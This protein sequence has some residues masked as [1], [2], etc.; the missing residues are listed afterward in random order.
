VRR[1][2][3]GVFDVRDFGAVGDG[4]TDDSSALNAA[5]WYASRFQTVGQ[6]AAAGARVV[7]PPGD[8]FC[9]SPVHLIGP[10]CLEGPSGGA[11]APAILRFDQDVGAPSDPTADD[12][13][14]GCVVLH[15]AGTSPIP[16]RVRAQAYDV[17]DL[18]VPVDGVWAGLY[19]R[20]IATTGDRKTSG[21]T[22]DPGF[23]TNPLANF[24]VPITDGNVTLA[25]W[26]ALDGASGAIVRRLVLTQVPGGDLSKT[27]S[28]V[29]MHAAGRLEDLHIQGFQGDGIH[30]R[31]AAVAGHPKLSTNANLWSMSGKVSVHDC[32]RYGMK[33][34]GPDSNAGH[35]E[36][37][38]DLTGNQSYGLWSKAPLGNLYGQI[39]T[40]GN[41]L[42]IDGGV[43]KHNEVVVTPDPA[44]PGTDTPVVLGQLCLPAPANR[45]G[46]QYRCTKA[47]RTDLVAEPNWAAHTDLD[48]PYF[49]DGTAHWT[50]FMEEGG[51]IRTVTGTGAI[52]VFERVYAEMNQQPA[53]IGTDVLLG[54]NAELVM[55]K[56]S[57]PLLGMAKGF[58]LP[59]SVVSRTQEA[60]PALVMQIDIGNLSDQNL[61]LRFRLAP[62]PE[63]FTPGGAVPDAHD[64]VF[65][66]TVGDP[67]GDYGQ[68]WVMQ[69]GTGAGSGVSYTQC[70]SIQLPESGAMCFP[71]LFLG[72]QIRHERRVTT[73]FVA[74][75]T[76]RGSRPD[77]TNMVSA[78]GAYRPGDVL[79]NNYVDNDGWADDPSAKW[80]VLW[81]PDTF[82]GVTTSGRS[83]DYP[84]RVGDV[85]YVGDYAYRAET[86]GLSGHDPAV[87]SWFAA[88]TGRGDLLHDATPVDKMDGDIEWRNVG[89]KTADLP[90]VPLLVERPTMA[91]VTTAGLA[92]KTLDADESAYARFKL[93]GADQDVTVNL[94]PGPANGWVRAF[95]NANTVAGGN[96]TVT[97]GIAGGGLTVPIAAE[98]LAMI[99]SDG[100]DCFQL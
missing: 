31:G 19:Y 40:H 42:V 51:S 61:G 33:I 15:A 82:G 7:V 48:E 26:G 56:D 28:G 100:N 35:V 22:D 27:C 95:W 62:S 20:V 49:V 16:T 32:G 86:A 88:T 1:A 59:H 79:L 41:G 29:R 68:R 66:R 17:G 80:P 10:S 69:A 44:W 93:V 38:L 8:Y 63:G 58:F 9:T 54:S 30:I 57:T 98:S 45:T 64:L 12:T 89:V 85:V 84:Y 65:K 23:L 34:Y 4:A 11:D 3:D 50:C 70:Q 76:P 5:L 13:D 78:F 75:D 77:T 87:A 47:G 96:Y 60:S 94:Q 67:F 72:S 21:A 92:T 73:A 2:H 81:R 97:V 25:L 14:D 83:D 37:I 36:G 91:T 46:F 74:A 52:N 71:K 99:F 6:T 39:H 43:W 55:T 53:S 24:G 18:I 90:F